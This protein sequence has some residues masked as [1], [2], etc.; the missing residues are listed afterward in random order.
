[1][2]AQLQ[3][4]TGQLDQVG[5]EY[6]FANVGG[7]L[8]R[9]DTRRGEAVPV[10]TAPQQPDVPS[11]FRLRAD[12]QG[13]E[14]IPGG[15]Q[16]PDVLAQQARVRGSSAPSVNVYTGQVTPSNQ[17]AAQSALIEQS[18]LLERLNGIQ[19]AFESGASEYLG[20]GGQIA[21]AGRAAMD[22]VAP[23]LMGETDR[24]KLREA[25]AFR[26]QIMT[27]FNQTLRDMSGAAVTQ[28][29]FERIRGQMP[30]PNDGPTVFAAKMQ[31]SIDLA[32]AAIRRQQYFLQNGIPFNDAIAAQMPLEQFL[33]ARPLQGPALGAP[34]GQGA[35]TPVSPGAERRY[36]PRTGTLE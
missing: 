20:L 18:G 14:Y 28:N 6:G 34:T 15:P 31:A 12:G 11:G 32:Q 30:A 4:V 19:S 13:L 29:E 33:S 17:T 21:T 36:N 3:A 25:A 8:V 7:T 35:S 2:R 22:F 26:S 16:D 5:G 27:N 9:T 1:L 10:F 24:A 23:G